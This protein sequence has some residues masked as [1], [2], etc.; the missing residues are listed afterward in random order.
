MAN[1]FTKLNYRFG[2]IEYPVTLK[3]MEEII[4][5]FPQTERKFYE[6]AIKDLK[7]VLKEDE[8]IFSFSTAD[9]KLTKTGFLVITDKQIV[10]VSM[11]GGLF[12]GAESEVVQYSDIVDVDFDIAPDPLGMAQMELGILNLKTKGGFGGKKRTIRNIPKNR[13]DYIVKLIREGSN[14]GI[15]TV[16]KQDLTIEKSDS[17]SNT[18][19]ADEIKKLATLKD[20]GILTEE[21]FNAK[22]KQLLGI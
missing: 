21:E 7:K 1:K 12:G 11:K 19:V 4:L 14:G 2:I 6:F 16:N 9:P 10:L 3:E 8:N 22:K 13:L 20:E 18:S 5:E 15:Q 17:P